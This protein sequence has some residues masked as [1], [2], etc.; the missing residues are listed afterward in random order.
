ML[1][2]QH[3]ASFGMNIALSVSLGW[4]LAILE[5]FVLLAS[6]HLLSF[7]FFHALTY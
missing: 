5:I 7:G 6:L 1:H 3:F 2:A 4:A